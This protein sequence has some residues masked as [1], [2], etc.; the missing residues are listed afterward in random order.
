MEELK[1]NCKAVKTVI[2]VH[3]DSEDIEGVISKIMD[4]VNIQ[5]LAAENQANAKALLREQE[6][7]TIQAFLDDDKEINTLSSLPASTLNKLVTAKCGKYEALYTMCERQSSSISHAIDGLRSV[8]SIR[9]ME[10]EKS[11]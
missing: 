8:L 2:E 3:V 5:G 9:K 4:L 7:K 11:I 6:N 10:M 1:A